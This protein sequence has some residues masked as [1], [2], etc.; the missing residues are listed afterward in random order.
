MS[1]FSFRLIA[2]SDARQ[3]QVE[4]PGIGTIDKL[5]LPIFP[6]SRPSLQYGAG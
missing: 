6:T 2:D 3:S 4:P 5:A 1:T